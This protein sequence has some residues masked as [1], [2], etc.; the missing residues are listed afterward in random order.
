M[1]FRRAVAGTLALLAAVIATAAA[2]R[3]DQAYTVSGRDTFRTGSGDVRS[4]T[5]YRGVQRLSITR[6]HGGT[7][8][9]AR[10]DYERDGDGG[11]QHQRA[12]FTSTLLPSGEQKD[13][14]GN[15]PAYL[16]VLNQPFAEQL[17]APTMR[18]LR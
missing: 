5:V 1:I 10:V 14:A 2:A 9:D 15:D 7:T 6:T 18:D 3:A 4:E 12:S 8:Y 13:G 16:T 11:K 17:D